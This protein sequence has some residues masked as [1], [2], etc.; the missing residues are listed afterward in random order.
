MT[1]TG[2]RGFPVARNA[3]YMGKDL[4]AMAFASNYHKWIIDEFSTRITGTVAEIGAGS[5]NL[6]A[7]I[8]RD[9]FDRLYA[10]EPA[11]TM[12]KR[13]E[14]RYANDSRVLTFNAYLSEKYKLFSGTL[15]TLIYNNVME[16][17]EDDEAA[18][19]A[20]ITALVPLTQQ[21]TDGFQVEGIVSASRATPP[22]FARWARGS[23]A[24]PRR[25]PT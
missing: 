10:L 11:P 14:Q 12:F 5:G 16:H 25:F 23:R 20:A 22:P 18:F 21:M 15:D 9:S 1:M 19:N 13:L 3:D 24:S 2:E 8:P 7:L 4:Q 6:T 17:I